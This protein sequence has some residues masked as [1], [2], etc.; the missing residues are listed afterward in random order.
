MKNY[1]NTQTQNNIDQSGMVLSGWIKAG[2][3]LIR[4]IISES[5]PQ[6][7]M[8]YLIILSHRNVKSDQCFPS[9]SLLAS[10]M[11]LSDRTIQR[12]INELCAL[13]VLIVNSG[14]QG[15]ANNYYFPR[16]DFFKEDTSVAMAYKR[17]TQFRKKPKSKPNM[18]EEFSFT[19]GD[20]AEKADAEW[21]D[22]FEF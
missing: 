10:E 9:I 14:K 5:N 20:L 16:E 6:T 15:I 21:D 4:H 8:L 18:T 19:Q 13:D 12:M 17:K 22:D 11:N 1:A 3:Q 2:N 7:A